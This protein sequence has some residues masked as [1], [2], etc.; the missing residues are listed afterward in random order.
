MMVD[1]DDIDEDPDDLNLNDDDDSW[2]LADKLAAA[3]QVWGAQ[4]DSMTWSSVPTDS[5]NG[6]TRHMGF[7][8]SLSQHREVEDED[9]GAYEDQRED[10]KMNSQVMEESKSQR[11]PAAMTA[12]EAMDV[13][14]HEEFEEGAVMDDMED[15]ADGED[16]ELEDIVKKGK[17][18]VQLVKVSFPSILPVT[19]R[20]F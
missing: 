7:T 2:P 3:R 17:P 16:E 11:E 13:D 4:E 9:E 14:V 12:E 5:Q 20:K 19:E 18:T 6:D 8:Q 15:D 10:A 1:Q